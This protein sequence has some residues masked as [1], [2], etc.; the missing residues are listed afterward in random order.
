MIAKAI[1]FLSEVKVEVKKV[2]W[3][4]RRE[5]MGGTMVVLVT[6]LLM[7]VFLGLVDMLLAKLVQSLI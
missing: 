6:V 1:Q 5:S 4:S 3:P 2:T 7:S